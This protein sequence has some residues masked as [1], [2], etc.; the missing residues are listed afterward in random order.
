MQTLTFAKSEY[1]AVIVGGRCAGAATA[2]L[3]ARA[4]ARVLVIDRDAYGADTISTHA[5]MR[6]GILLLE[7][8]GL[9]SGIREAGTP[10]VRQARFIYGPDEIAIPIRPDAAVEAL[11]APRRTVLDRLLVDAATDAGAVFLFNTSLEALTFDNTGRVRGAIARTSDGTCRNISAN[12]VIGAD[13]RQSRVAEQVK[14]N[15]IVSKPERAALVFGYFTGIDDRGYQWGY[16]RD[17]A[18]GAI[19]TNF[20]QHCLFASVP[21]HAFREVFGE[22][23]LDGLI[24]QFRA[25]DPGLADQIDPAGMEGELR[26]FGGAP[27]HLRQACGPGWALVGDAGY[28]KD[29]LT[30][31]G[32]TDALRDADLLARA[33]CAGTEEALAAYRRTR[34]ELSLPFLDVTAEIASFRWNPTTIRALHHRLNET[35]KLEYASIAHSTPTL[36]SAA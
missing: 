4:G 34:D 30:A 28:F 6:T 15:T 35:M 1:D 25:H 19:P 26:R 22:G 31:H 11:Y 24:R 36:K 18:I 21:K 12:I 16:R 17:N 9:G 2:L 7:R 14:A 8:W 27:G 23:L 10:P 33:L 3:L 5:L 20:G 29:P 13:G 32:I